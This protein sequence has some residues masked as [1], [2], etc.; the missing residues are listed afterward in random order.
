MGQPAS[1]Q[2]DKVVGTDTHIVMVP[3][4]GGPQPVPMPFPFSGEIVS[5]TSPN[6]VI[7][8][9]PAATVGSVAMNSPPHVP[10]GGTFQRPPSNQ[11]TIIAGSLTV[12]I[13]GKPAARAGDKARTCNDPVDLPAG[14]IVAQGR[15][16]IG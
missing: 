1:K 2:G 3:S 5:G 7:E 14:S 9:R 6:V 4:P 12:T 8:G 11:A 16:F 13:N 15:V 10:T